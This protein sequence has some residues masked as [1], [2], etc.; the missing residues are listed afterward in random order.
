MADRPS[1]KGV[2]GRAAIEGDVEGVQRGL[3]AHGPPASAAATR[4]PR[5]VCA[6]TPTW[7]GA[8]AVMIL[9]AATIR[10]WPPHEVAALSRDP[11][12]YW[13]EPH[14]SLEPDPSA[15]PILVTARYSVPAERREEFVRAMQAVRWGLFRDG[16]SPDTMVEVYE[17]ATWDE[18]LR[19]HSG[20]LTGA[21]QEAEQRARG[22]VEGA[23]AISH[24]FPARPPAA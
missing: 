8:A 9:A 19:Q 20:R 1:R 22:L 12:S 3:P 5:S 21:D 17:V 18:H 24:L 11:A 2:I 15:G 4:S 23:P 7:P 10:F 13:L 14:L 16:E 6:Q